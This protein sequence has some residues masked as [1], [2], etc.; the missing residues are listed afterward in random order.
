[1]LHYHAQLNVVC[2]SLKYDLILSLIQTQSLNKQ[3][4]AEFDCHDGNLITSCLAQHLYFM[5]NVTCGYI[6][7]SCL[8]LCQTCFS[9]CQL[10]V[11]VATGATRALPPPLLR[12][13]PWDQHDMM[14]WD[15]SR[16]ALFVRR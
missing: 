2:F 13:R 9:L 14:D 5:K 15:A 8:L 16:V 4:F 11:H 6:T 3:A 10:F 7:E 1:M 12:G